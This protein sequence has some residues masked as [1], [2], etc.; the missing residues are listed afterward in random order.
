LRICPRRRVPRSA[1]RPTRSRA[2]SRGRADP[3]QRDL[4]GGRVGADAVAVG[5]L[6]DLVDG[7]ADSGELLIQDYARP[8]LLLEA[9]AVEDATRVDDEVGCVDDA[10]LAQALGVSRCLQLVV[11]AARDHAAAQ[12]RDGA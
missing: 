2:R 10:A 5:P 4:A 9:A 3:A 6:Q 12:G 7:I 11:G 1:S 8:V